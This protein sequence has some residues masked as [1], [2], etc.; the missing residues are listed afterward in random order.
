MLPGYTHRSRTRLHQLDRARAAPATTTTSTAS[1]ADLCS[2]LPRLPASQSVL[3]D[4]A[5]IEFR[6]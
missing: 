2:S 5:L 6:Y 3:T 4:L 1:S